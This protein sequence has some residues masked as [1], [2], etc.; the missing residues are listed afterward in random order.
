MTDAKDN[1]TVTCLSHKMKYKKVACGKQQLHWLELQFV[2]ENNNPVS[3]LNVQ[4]E[5]H[6]LATAAELALWTRG[7][8]TQFDPTPPPNPPAGVTDSQ[9]L[10]RFDDLYWIAVDVKTDG[11]QLADEMEQRPLGIRRNPNSQPVSNNLF[12]PETR[13]PTWRSDVQEKAE[14]TGYR[15]HYVT[16]G[17]LCDRLPDMPGWTE[18][19]PPKFHFPTGKELKGTEIAR[20]ALEQRHVIEICPLR[21]WVLSL[22]DTKDYDLA[23]GL[24]L[25][26]MADIVYAAESNNPTIDYFFQR[27]CQ[28]LSCIPQFAEYPSWF[29]TLA[30]DVPFRERYQPPVYLNTGEGPT[31]EGD[32]RLFT[33]EC[34][35]HVLV[36]WCGTDSLLNILTDL[37]FAPK[38]CLPELAGAGNVHGGF[39]DAYQLAKRKFGDKFDLRAIRT[40]L[41]KGKSLFICGH[42]LGGALALLYAAEI[43]D[44][45][46]VLY[47][48]GMP[49]TFT[50]SA[51]ASL[52]DIKHYRHVNDNDTITQIPPDADLDNEFYRTWGPL[53]DK[54]GFDWSLATAA[55]LSVAVRDLTYQSTGL[56]EKKDP[57]WHHGSTVIFF[58]AQQCA[59]RAASP[60]QK[61][62]VDGQT[63]SRHFVAT[64][65]YVVPS[66]NE[67]CLKSTGEHQASFIQCLN[68]ASLAKTFPKNTNPALN[69]I[70]TD[71]RSH[72][73]AHRYLP[74]IHNQLLELADPTRDMNREEMRVMFREEVEKGAAYSNPDE[75]ERNREFLA[76]QD[77]LPVAL[78]RTQA[79]ETGKNALLRFAAVTEEEVELS[80]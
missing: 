32:T 8:H 51:I 18:T 46:P 39:L 25:G 71:P 54:L 35:A 68:P 42:S 16:I 38:Q 22:H 7:G 40:S 59:M 64:K 29:H 4:L 62:L 41:D 69:G 11:Q 14:A 55:G 63:Y 66:L 52:G 33:V 58:R 26:I 27:K 9:G 6:P 19:D 28:D 12:R 10:V 73:M 72:S 60:Y 57:Y 48:Y 79:K 31:G 15:H 36:A 65:L 45:Q 56:E 20:D 70:G 24:N 37:S 17:E 49:R 47:T 78:R 61:N 30:V 43:K 50:R 74:Y 75:V 80:Q 21:A 44:Y 1:T 13:D 3:G 34:A 23:N 5:Y 77:M 76:L 53:G 67:E 2:D